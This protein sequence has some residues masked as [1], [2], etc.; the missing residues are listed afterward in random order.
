MRFVGFLAGRLRLHVPDDLRDLVVQYGV[1]P[2]AATFIGTMYAGESFEAWLSPANSGDKQ[3]LTAG[4]KS[5]A[6]LWF[7]TP[8]VPFV[9][10][11][12]LVLLAHLCEPTEGPSIR[13]R[14]A[15]LVSIGVLATSLPRLDLVATAGLPVAVMISAVAAARMIYVRVVSVGED[16]D[17]DA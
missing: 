16:D 11:L 2:F 9:T 5:I 7:A 12:L 14:L 17:D 3:P 15:N 13:Q 10:A 8:L 6:P 1:V 4:L